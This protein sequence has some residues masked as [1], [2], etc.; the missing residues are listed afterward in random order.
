[1]AKRRLVMCLDGTWN[2]RDDTTNVFHH[3]ALALKDASGKAQN[4]V[5]QIKF[6]L[7]GVGT[8]VLDGISGGAFGFGLEGNVRAAYDWLV[9][10]Y[11]DGADASCTDEIYIFGFSRGAYTARSLVGF[12]AMCGLLR[13]GAPLSV[14]QLW[15]D[16]C[17]LG[18][19]REHRI[20]FWDKVFGSA[21]T[22]TRRITDLILD[23][24][25]IE[26]YEEKRGEGLS[27]TNGGVTKPNDRVPGQLLDQLNTREW[28]LVRWSRRVRI[29]YLG[30]YDTVGALGLD[31]LAIPGIK[32]KLA[33][34]HNMRATTIVQNC[35]H[36]L[37]IDENRS[38]FNH[39]PFL[40]YVGH[41]AE[42]EDNQG[43]ALQA[44]DPETHWK[45]A[46][47]MWCRKIEQRWFVGAHSNIG[48]GYPDN[49]L[50]QGP[51]EWLLDGA[52]KLGLEAEPFDYA[53]PQG[54]P[55]VRD[56]FAEFAKPWWTEIIRGKRFY[57]R[58]QPPPEL[59][60]G[61]IKQNDTNSPASGFTLRS[62]NEHVDQSVFDRVAVDP[63]YRPPNL[64]EYAKREIGETT[65]SPHE[66]RLKLLAES[67]SRHAWIGETASKNISLLLW[68]TL[69]TAG[70]LAVSKLAQVKPALP[71]WLL[72]GAAFAFVLVDW[73]ESRATFSLALGPP[74]ARW[75]AFVDAVYW[76]RSL[77]FVL[78]ILGAVMGGTHLWR[79][80][81][82]ADSVG[83]SWKATEAIIRGWWSV[84]I[85][86]GVA[87]ALAH[88]LDASSKQF[89][90]AVFGTVGGWV[91]SFGSATLII[92]T[93]WLLGRILAPM[94]GH[95]P[96]ANASRPTEE[97][98]FAGLLLVLQ[99]GLAVFLNTFDWVG[100][101]MSRVNLGSI[102]QLQRR[103]TPT[104]V[105]RCLEN[106]RSMLACEWGKEDQ[107][108]V[109]GPAAETMRET[110]R[111]A[112]WR[113]VFG[114]IPGYWMI[115]TFALW[116][117]GTKLNCRWLDEHYIGLPL[118]VWMPLLAAIADYCEDFCH[119]RYLTLHSR[120]QAP[121]AALPLFSVTM[122]MMKFAMLLASGLLTLAALAAG[123]C[124]VA[125]LGEKT[126]WRGTLSL[127]ISALSALLLITI[128][129]GAIAYRLRNRQQ[130]R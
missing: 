81:W 77:A 121:S 50:A 126:G 95:G 119:L 104:G 113:D 129:I 122:T 19:E 43:R 116:F 105:T 46:H 112:L 22:E 56:S 34:H 24:W 63:T 115:L 76:V 61:P 33:L 17:I 124:D 69:A 12:I 120:G 18:R 62:I 45:Q 80:G 89:K 58:L 13:R 109:K 36:A 100:E 2:N 94:L 30:V 42:E 107:D 47:A 7:K 96:P 79:M 66:P 55:P 70:L 25:R 37:A 4:A 27:E 67:K 29:T 117:A 102:V 106:W 82:H 8:G 41:A 26:R 60:A 59:Y 83:Q 53:R 103:F 44:S 11:R 118:W 86:A 114:Y 65:A 32:S 71:A 72:C 49:Q 110:V 93:G 31:A 48:G 74:T 1:M 101:P 87:T 20:S 10:Q 16:Y 3:F 21:P 23:P 125:L 38:S 78:F 111:E 15:D 84:P 98:E 85:A 28:L 6:Y 75:R 108:A 128:L 5:S 123:I 54:L 92:F 68:A 39:T 64:V 88:S 90:T 127:L 14:N 99:I 51:L 9:E 73:G 35:R 57:R 52:R 130:E 97:A 40:E 91:L